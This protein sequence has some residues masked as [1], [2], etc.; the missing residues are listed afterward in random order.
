M[1][2]LTEYEKA[3]ITKYDLLFES[4]LSRTESTCDQL[5]KEM[6]EV[7]VDLRWIIGIMLGGFGSIFAMMA[8]GFKWF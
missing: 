2:D 1:R 7:K 3:T 8:H 4:R 6:K 5:I